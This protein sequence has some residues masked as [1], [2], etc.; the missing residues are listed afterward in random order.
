MP[1]RIPKMYNFMGVS[2][3]NFELLDLIA[4]NYP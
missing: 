2:I 3:E 4:F 1:P